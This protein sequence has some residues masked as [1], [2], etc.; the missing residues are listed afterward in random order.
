MSRIRH[1]SV[2]RTLWTPF[3]A[4]YRK[5]TSASIRETS[6]S[7]SACRACCYST[8]SQV[9]THPP[10]ISK[11]LVANRGE[12]ACRVLT[13]AKRL[14]VRTVAVYSEADRRSAFVDLADE[15]YCIGPPPARDS[16][17]RADVVLQ[18]AKQSQ[19]D[20]IHPGYGFLSENARFSEACQAASIKF[21]GPPAAAI[22]SM[23]DKSQAKA[24]MSAAGVP[25]VP[26]YHGDDQADDRLWSEADGIGF[27]LL[28]KA[29]SGGG[30]KGMKL[31]ASKTELM[32]AIHSARRE[33]VASFNDD[34]LLLERYI[35]KPRH[36]EVQVI[37]DGHG[38]AV[39][40]FDRDCSVQRRHQKIIE[41]AP[42]PG[43]PEQFHRHIG[44]AAVRAAHAVGYVNAGTVEFIVD[45]DSQDFYFMEMNTRLQVEHPVTEAVA[46]V[47]LVE[48]QLRVAAGEQLPMTQEQLTCTGHAFEA[49]LYAEKPKHNFLP[50]AGRVRRWR[51]PATAGFFDH[52][53]T[54]RVD[55]G[56][57]EGDDVGTNYDPM[58]AKLI[59]KGRDRAEALQAMRQAL[60]DVQVAGLPTNV[61]FLQRLTQHDAFL[62]LELDT[63]FIGRHGNTLLATTPLQ[64][65]LAALAAVARTKLKAA[66]AQA[67]NPAGPG[68][69]AWA[70]AD[71]KRLWYNLLQPCGMHYS[72]GDVDVQLQLKYITDT[73]FEVELS[74]GA[75]P[76]A[77][78]HVSLSHDVLAAEVDGQLLRASV[79]QYS[80]GNEQVLTLWMDGSS[81]EFRWETPVWSKDASAIAT[82]GAIVTPM[83]GKVV[84]VLVNNGQSVV[85]GQALLVMEAMK[86][87]HMVSAPCD[88]VVDALSLRVGAQIDDGQ[89]LLHVLTPAT[90]N[91]DQDKQPTATQ[92]A[93]A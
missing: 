59:T 44:E 75:K 72:E 39:Y 73:E 60:A 49:R 45:V 86:M 23:G 57:R 11:L 14:G 52:R 37:A 28:V 62:N 32:D 43:L 90:A 7:I 34:R 91:G 24:I 48:L 2:L 70:V 19:A 56:V 8:D 68:M 21:V 92:A 65:R 25:V 17:L 77:V 30:G 67:A 12:I 84:K 1:L 5:Q 58:I 18:V 10:A 74:S 22:R 61:Q 15:S 69:G 76:I 16:Y 6:L 63:G 3:T 47:D 20:A 53:H 82:S 80:H 4:A 93:T 31:A 83:P 41:E 81:H 46:N 29:V 13:T 88:G 66:A 85:K 50:G 33:A 64:P 9:P 27:P 87:E 42:A 38:H 78:R 79:L 55:S 51:V 89:V 36:V 71:G 54:I 35:T 26:G 40:L